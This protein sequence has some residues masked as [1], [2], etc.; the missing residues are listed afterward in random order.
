M[1]QRPNTLRLIWAKR[2]RRNQKHITSDRYSPKISSNILYRPGTK[3]TS[4]FTNT[5][6][7]S[8]TH[9]FCEEKRKVRCETDLLEVIYWYDEFRIFTAMRTVE[10]HVTY[11]ENEDVTEKQGDFHLLGTVFCSFV[12][13]FLCNISLLCIYPPF[14]LDMESGRIINHHYHYKT[15]YEECLN[16]EMF[17]NKLIH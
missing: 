14:S 6:P 9:I 12:F 8:T 11:F 13:C 16:K 7:S 15:W 17:R 1:T 3:V 4:R 5:P 10:R 2:G